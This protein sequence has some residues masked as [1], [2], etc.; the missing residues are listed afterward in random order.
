MAEDSIKDMRIRNITLQCDGE[1]AIWYLCKGVA[2]RF[3]NSAGTNPYR[4]TAGHIAPGT[5]NKNR[6]S[7]NYSRS[8]F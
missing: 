6:L 8:Q 1:S 7:R 3:T 4:I 2:D 5:S